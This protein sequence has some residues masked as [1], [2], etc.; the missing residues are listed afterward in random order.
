LLLAT[1]LG[2]TCFNN[3]NERY[4]L[5]M[6]IIFPPE[7]LKPPRKISPE[8]AEKRMVI[9]IAAKRFRL[10]LYKDKLRAESKFYT[11]GIAARQR[12]KLSFPEESKWAD[13]RMLENKIG[14]PRGRPIVYDTPPWDYSDEAPYK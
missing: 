2:L 1:W 8:L 3:N 14:F 11:S 5:L 13:D 6:K 4:R 7:H 12:F 9:K 10:A